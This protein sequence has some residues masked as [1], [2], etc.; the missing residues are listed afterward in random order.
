MSWIRLSLG[1]ALVTWT[2]GCAQSDSALELANRTNAAVLTVDAQLR[3]FAETQRRV[4]DLEIARLGVFLKGT[5]ETETELQ[6]ILDES[7]GNART[8]YTSLQTL[9]GQIAA[10]EVKTAQEVAQLRD[11]LRKTQQDILLPKDTISGLSAKLA[12]LGEEKDLGERISF[13]VEF[14]SSVK[15]S[16]DKAKKDKE[17]ALRKAAGGSK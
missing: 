10:S 16:I 13:L 17:A 6:E 15:E 7:P 4:A 2:V 14:G 11:R 1:L 8:L 9:A 3:D 12:V 5:V